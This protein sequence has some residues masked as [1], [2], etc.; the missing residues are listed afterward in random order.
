M[1]NVSDS[2]INA[3]R[4]TTRSDNIYG[5]LT[6]PDNSTLELTTSNISEGG[7]SITKQCIDGDELEFGKALLGELSLSIRSD[8]S[9]YAFYDSTI[10]LTYQVKLNDGTWEDVPL[11]I[12]TVTEAIK[13]G[14]LVNL[15][16]YDNLHLLDIKLGSTVLNGDL[17][18][19]FE[20]I[21]ADTKLELGFDEDYIKSLPNGDDTLQIDSESGC[22]TYRDAVKLICQLVGCFALATR[23]GKLYIKPFTTNSVATLTSGHRYNLTV[24]DYICSYVELSVTG[25]K[26]TFVKH[27]DV[28]TKTGLTM[29]ISD[30]PAW[31]YGTNELMQNRVNE[32]YNYL[33]GITYT[34]IDMELPG[35]PAFD[36]GDCITLVTDDGNIST[37]ITSYE[38]NYHKSMTITSDG[39]NPYLLNVSTQGQKSSRIISQESTDNKLS[40]YTFTNIDDVTIGD[41]E[42]KLVGEVEFSST[43]DTTGIFSITIQVLVTVDDTFVEESTEET[44]AVPIKIYDKDGNETTVKDSDGNALTFSAS[45]KCTHTNK[46]AKPGIM[47]AKVHYRL[48]DEKLEYEAIEELTAGYHLITLVYPI[49]SIES[50]TRYTWKVY[51]EAGGTGTIFIP[52]KTVQAYLI[53]QS[54][55]GGTVEWDGKIEA[56]DY[57]SRIKLGQPHLGVRTFTG[58]LDEASTQIPTSNEF[59]ETFGRITLGSKHF[60]LRTLTDTAGVN[61]VITQQTVSFTLNNYVEV[62]ESN[63]ISL[64]TKY[65]YD[66]EIGTIDDGKICTV[67]A[68]TS[69]KASVDDITVEVIK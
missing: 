66:G 54:L 59:A 8:K 60:K 16:A 35:D 64:R 46:Y 47:T 30:A 21:S 11:G 5:T 51:M 25:L 28:K 68:I 56:E 63:N 53:G 33:A 17:Y 36:C 48:N 2:Y 62:N 13:Q 67:T 19:I 58:T 31:D 55:A 6:F 57:V 22:E 39:A 3:V 37:I 20:L 12:Y 7:V 14:V 65:V 27:D 41:T 50:K 15:T 9:R 44:L 23:D 24:A 29:T 10:S 38:W 69:D 4:A 42:E 18:S 34:P 61:V 52:F 26:G 45:S 43:S 32:L 40:I 1:Y 49:S